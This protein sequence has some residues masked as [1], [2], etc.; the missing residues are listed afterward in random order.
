MITDTDRINALGKM[1]NIA[2]WHGSWAPHVPEKGGR[3]IRSISEMDNDGT[4]V[5]DEFT[6]G[7]TTFKTMIK[8][9]AKCP[10]CEQSAEYVRTR[11]FRDGSSH[12]FWCGN[13]ECKSHDL[14]FHIDGIDVCQ[15]CGGAGQFMDSEGL[16]ELCEKCMGDGGKQ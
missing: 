7:A 14:Y 13:R 11:Y 10:N 5:G 8:P 16:P 15:E 6:R 9:I 12:V 3:Q 1:G 2:V 4:E